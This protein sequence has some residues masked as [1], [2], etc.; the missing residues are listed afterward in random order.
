[1]SGA[2]LRSG[3]ETHHV[4]GEYAYGYLSAESGVHRLV[5]LSPFKISS[6]AKPS[7]RDLRMVLMLK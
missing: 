6:W 3:V 1:M 7:A 2:A 5:G 4:E